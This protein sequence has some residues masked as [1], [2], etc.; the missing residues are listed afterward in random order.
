MSLAPIE[1]ALIIT[2]H[3]NGFTNSKGAFLL[4]DIKPGTLVAVRM[5]GYETQEFQCGESAD[6]LTIYLKPQEVWLKEVRI[7]KPRNYQQDSIRLRK[8]YEKVF[9]TKESKFSQLFIKR[10]PGFKSSSPFINPQSTASL[11]SVDALQLIGLLSGRKTATSKLKSLLVEDEKQNYIDHIFSKE[12]IKSVTG[13][14]GEELDAFRLRYRPDIEKAK[15]MTAYEC[16]LYIKKCY[17]EFR[18]LPLK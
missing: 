2:P 15:S 3:Q 5:M 17:E 18:V 9:N 1:N 8:E 6:S 14:E 12:R 13:L 7:F 11:I 4:K 10:D 16:I